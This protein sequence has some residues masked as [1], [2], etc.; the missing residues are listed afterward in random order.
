MQA[1]RYQ[2]LWL[3]GLL[4]ISGASQGQSL[5][6]DQVSGPDALISFG[7][8]VLG[9]GRL[10]QS[11]TPQQPAIGFVQFETVLYPAGGSSISR[12]HLRQGGFEGS[13]LASTDPLPIGG[14]D[15]AVRTYYFQNNI[16]I[17]PGQMYWLEIELVSISSPAVD[18][19]F[20]YHR[21]FGYM[22]GDL[23]HEGFQNAGLDFWFREGTV[24]PEPASLH[25]LLIG[26]VAWQCRRFLCREAFM[27]AAASLPKSMEPTGASRSDH[28]RI[29][30]QRRLAPAAHAQRSTVARPAGMNRRRFGRRNK[31]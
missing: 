1:S 16:P 14:N 26:A 25:L 6:F 11:F 18:M 29:G 9:N 12:I 3:L 2:T 20:Q 19:S 21:D 30:S 13:L 27:C 7:L 10:S 4:A 23:Y 15:I 24:V 17:T 8:P 22:G 31:P 5:L 28:F